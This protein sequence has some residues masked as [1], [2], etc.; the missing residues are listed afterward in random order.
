MNRK[1]G[2][3]AIAGLLLCLGGATVQAYADTD[4]ATQPSAQDAAAS[5]SVKGMRDPDWNDDSV[6]E[7]IF[8][9]N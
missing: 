7:L 9:N 2:M 5:V 1:M 4:Q 3:R 6:I 8:D